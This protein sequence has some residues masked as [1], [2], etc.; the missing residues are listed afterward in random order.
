MAASLFLAL[1]HSKLTYL[2]VSSATP[3]A[4]P[5][6]I[7]PGPYD[8]KFSRA[9]NLKPIISSHDFAPDLPGHSDFN[10]NLVPS[11]LTLPNGTAALVV[12]SVNGTS[13]DPAK[14]GT[15]S[16]TLNPDMLTL[17]TYRSAPGDTESIRVGPIA[18]SNVI[19]K[20]VGQQEA[21]G[22]QDPRIVYNP[23]DKTFYMTYCVYG[24]PLPQNNKTNPL[25]ILCGGAGVGIATTQTPHIASSWVRHGYNCHNGTHNNCGKSAAM[26]IRESGP[27]Y[28]FFGIPS[29]AVSTSH[30]LIHWTLTDGSWMV[31]D[32]AAQEMWIEAGS[33]PQR[34]SDGNYI[35]TYNIAD[36]NLWWGIG[37][38]ILD[39]DD[40]TKVIQRE[41]RAL[42][43]RLDWERA[44]P[45]NPATSWEYYKNCIGAMNSLQPLGNDTFVGFYVGGDSVCGAATITVNKKSS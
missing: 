5:L 27:H 20:P 22:V 19:L 43:P 3:P 33:P 15:T 4:S 6:I 39:K 34:L 10:F 38:L 40:P 42:W 17:T 32:G 26:L 29:I 37:Y 21:C 13:W 7:I 14:N 35:M 41:S 2:V 23:A 12:R 16:T 11:F 18:S 24:P 28:M 30:D 1:L 44:N 8:V 36:T 9:N 31:P 45:V 25:G